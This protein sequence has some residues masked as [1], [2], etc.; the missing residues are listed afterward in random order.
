MNA[1]GGNGGAHGVIQ[2]LSIT[3]PWHRRR[4][5]PA[6]GRSSTRRRWSPR[7]TPFGSATCARR[8]KSSCA[9]TPTVKLLCRDGRPAHGYHGSRE[10]GN[11]RNAGGLY[12]SRLVRAGTGAGDAHLVRSSHALNGK[13]ARCAT[14]AALAACKLRPKQKGVNHV[15]F[16]HKE[17]TKRTARCTVALRRKHQLRNLPG[18][19][20][21]ACSVLCALCRCAGRRAR[22]PT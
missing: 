4:R 18:L 1:V 14:L 5:A 2:R 8:G 3:R 17:K 16:R 15:P 19:Q 22:A 21:Q 6:A 11:E 13:R 9:A 20:A 12:R 7:E 10:H